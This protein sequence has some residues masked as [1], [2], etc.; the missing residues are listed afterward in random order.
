MTIWREWLT[1]SQVCGTPAGQPCY[2]MTSGGPGALPRRYAGKPHAGRE[3]AAVMSRGAARAAGSDT[4]RERSGLTGSEPADLAPGAAPRTKPPV[5]RV[6]AGK[7]A[8]VAAWQ[9]LAERQRQRR[10]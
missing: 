10:Q 7:Q 3:R 1:C 5:R 4:R 2:A 6:A 9:A 8:T